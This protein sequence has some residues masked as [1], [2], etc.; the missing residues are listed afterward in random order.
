ML[1]RNHI[2]R[3][4]IHKV[5]QEMVNEGKLMLNRGKLVAFQPH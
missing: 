2:S 3:S 4:A 1:S 5:L